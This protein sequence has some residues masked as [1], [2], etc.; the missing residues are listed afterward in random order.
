MPLAF[1]LV[2]RLENSRYCTF[3]FVLRKQSGNPDNYTGQKKVRGSAYRTVP[4]Q[5]IHVH[6]LPSPKNYASDND[7]NLPK[8][9]VYTVR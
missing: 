9:C 7:N 1:L 8:L 2:I 4:P 5:P 3:D 6:P